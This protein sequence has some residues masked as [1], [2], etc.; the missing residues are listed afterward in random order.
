VDF[1]DDNL[2]ALAAGVLGVIVIVTAIVMTVR[3]VGLWRAIKRNRR[4]LDSHLAGIQAGTARTQSGVAYLQGLGEDEK[5]EIA[6]I[7]GHLAELQVLAGEAGRAFA[8]LRAP[9]RYI[10]R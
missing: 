1:V 4:R 6:R 9:L 2:I 3:L 5:A 7:R 8:I 10:G